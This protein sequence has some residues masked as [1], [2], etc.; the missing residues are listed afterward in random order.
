MG[1][2]GLKLMWETPWIGFPALGA[3]FLLG[4]IPRLP[5]APLVLVTAALIGWMTGGIA[6]AHEA[7]VVSSGLHL[8]TPTWAEVW[9]SLGIAVLPLRAKLSQCARRAQ[10]KYAHGLAACLDCLKESWPQ[11]VMDLPHHTVEPKGS[12]EV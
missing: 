4:Q 9:R 7:V 10:M 12:R 8:V 6:P 2:L 1:V 3:L 11:I 5:A